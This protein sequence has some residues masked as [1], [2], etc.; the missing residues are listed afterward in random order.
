MPGVLKILNEG[1]K[2]AHLEKTVDED[3]LG[4][5]VTITEIIKAIDSESFNDNH[6]VSNDLR[7]YK[8][9]PNV[10][11]ERVEGVKGKYQS[12]IL[13]DRVI[14]HVLYTIPPIT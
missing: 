4:A 6:K 9:H 10:Q 7:K 1:V 13:L 3:Y 8:D 11:Y 2:V 14:P 5:F 12:K